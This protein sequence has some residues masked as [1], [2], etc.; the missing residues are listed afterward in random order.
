MTALHLALQ[1]GLAL[2]FLSWLLSV[3]IGESHPKASA[4]PILIEFP[5]LASSAVC[6][7]GGFWGGFLSP[8]APLNPVLAAWEAVWMKLSF[9]FL[10]FS[11]CL[12]FQVENCCLRAFSIPNGHPFLSASS[13][14]TCL[15]LLF[16]A[17][18]H[19]WRNIF[20]FSVLHRWGF[21]CC[22]TGLWNWTKQLEKKYFIC[23]CFE[24]KP[25]IIK[26]IN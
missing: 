1:Q 22:L 5:R 3:S 11:C 8:G 4:L 23:Y 20:W 12:F 9:G 16:C 25:R 24:E 15:V 21:P 17:H 10:V 2:C 14:S 19:E 13:C 26:R 7:C 18:S 6:F